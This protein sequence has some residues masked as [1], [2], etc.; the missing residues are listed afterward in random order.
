MSGLHHICTSH[1]MGWEAYVE[2]LLDYMY[3]MQNNTCC[4]NPREE[5]I[6]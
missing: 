4:G 6:S 5:Y 1:F 3:G 2:T